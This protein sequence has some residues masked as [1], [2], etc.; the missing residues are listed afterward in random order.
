[1]SFSSTFNGSITITAAA[2]NIGESFRV[3]D[4][5]NNVDLAPTLLSGCLIIDGTTVK[6][7]TNVPGGGVAR[8]TVNNSSSISLLVPSSSRFV[9]DIDLCKNLCPS[10]PVIPALSTTTIGTV[11][12]GNT[13]NLTSITASNTPANATLTWHTST[14]ASNANKIS[15]PTAVMAGTYSAAFFYSNGACYS[16]ANGTGTRTVTVTN[17][18][19]CNAGTV[20]P[21]FN[22]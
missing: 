9:F 10:T 17:T 13:A 16:D 19:C 18:I 2:V 15:N 5:T 4:N 20:A 1:M 21:M 12:P 7:N 8:F 3:R 14:P 6:I 22:Q 11:C